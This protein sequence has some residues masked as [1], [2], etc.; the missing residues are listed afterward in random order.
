MDDDKWF[1]FSFSFPVSFFFSTWLDLTFPEARSMCFINLEHMSNNNDAC[2]LIIMLT[3][4]CLSRAYSRSSTSKPASLW[5][6]W[7]VM[8]KSKSGMAACESWIELKVP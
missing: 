3:L 5:P 2:I 4:G 6:Q 7:C 1:S 8:R